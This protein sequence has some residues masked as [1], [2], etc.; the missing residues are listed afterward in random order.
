MPHA[1]RR[2]LVATI[3]ASAMLLTV[4]TAAMAGPG[5]TKKLVESTPVGTQ[6]PATIHDELMGVQGSLYEVTAALGLNRSGAATGAGIGIAIIDT[7]VVDVP[8]LRASNVTIGP[9]FSLD[10][11]D[12]S[13]IGRDLHGH[14]THLASLIA[15]TDQAWAEGDRGRKPGRQI[16]VAPDANLISVKVGAANGA[17]DVTQAIA[18]IN[19]VIANRQAHNIRVLSLSYGTDSVQPWQVDPL[20]HAVER[21]WH[22]GIVVVVA[23][24]NDGQDAHA[25]VNPATNPWVLSVGAADLT[26]DGTWVDGGGWAAAASFSSG[27]DAWIRDVVMIAPGRSIVG[28]RVV[29]SYSDQVNQAGRVG[30]QLVAA[31]G[32]SQAAAVM[33]GVVAT[34]LEE[35][36]W[37]TPDQVKYIA[38]DSGRMV[39]AT[40]A[41]Y[42][43]ATFPDTVRAQ[44]EDGTTNQGGGV[45]GPVTQQH[46]LSSGTGSID[47]ARGTQRIA[48][49]GVELAGDQDV[50]GN[51]HS[52]TRWTKDSWADDSWTSGGWTASTDSSG[53]WSGAS[54]NGASWNGASWNGLSW[55]GASWNGSSYQ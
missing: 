22:A 20:S 10:A 35:R 47:A 44:R 25:F 24:G 18:G 8:A 34:M 30:D 16:G 3:T 37:L 1:L 13:T 12:T 51:D 36:P 21:A 38:H 14:G 17:V 42:D 15:S 32:S 48:I 41:S 23:A 43:W 50:F 4:P 33:A 55:N 49:D 46:E 52:A 45:W 6:T 11:F 5:Q 53:A 26:T 2:S 29:G 7:G 31:S 27:T 54:W 28:S 39:D 40:D 19:W 9:D